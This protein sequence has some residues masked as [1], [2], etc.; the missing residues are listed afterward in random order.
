MCCVRRGPRCYVHCQAYCCARFIAE[1]ESGLGNRPQD[2]LQSL[3]LDHYEMVLFEL[4]VRLWDNL[5]FAPSPPLEA[6]HPNF[7]V[8]IDCII[9]APLTVIASKIGF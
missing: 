3:A 7:F 5:L 6:N 9:G 1:G 2:S 4:H 8:G